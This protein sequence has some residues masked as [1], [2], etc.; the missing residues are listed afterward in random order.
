M[1]YCLTCWRREQWTEFCRH[2]RRH[3]TALSTLTARQQLN[4]LNQ[5]CSAASRHW[6]LEQAAAG[7]KAQQALQQRS[8][9]ASSGDTEAYSPLLCDVTHACTSTNIWNIKYHAYMF[10]RCMSYG[11]IFNDDSQKSCTGMSIANAWR[12]Q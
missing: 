4:W 6:A 9:R 11:Y 2:K 8:K 10:V 5:Q 1:F 3:T 12:Q 7:S